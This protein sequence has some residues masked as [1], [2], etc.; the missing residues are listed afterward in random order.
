M[1]VSF[2]RDHSH[3]GDR[4]RGWRRHSFRYSIII[5]KQEACYRK[6]VF[7]GVVKTRTTTCYS[8][9]HAAVYYQ[10]A[11]IVKRSCIWIEITFIIAG[12]YQC[13][14][15]PCKGLS[16]GELVF[17]QVSCNSFHHAM[18]KHHLMRQIACIL[19]AYVAFLVALTD[20]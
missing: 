14:D 6:Q 10:C 2:Y 3:S 1:A 19:T 7:I 11:G 17:R 5:G 13:V 20:K 9:G 4:A 18:D 8:N 16:T 12:R 15:L